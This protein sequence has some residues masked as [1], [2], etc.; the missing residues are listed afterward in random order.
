MQGSK[1]KVLK[2]VSLCEMADSMELNPFTYTSV[3]VFS[4][5][6]HRERIFSLTGNQ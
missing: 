4:G 2:V 3:A 6:D 1:Q 5:I